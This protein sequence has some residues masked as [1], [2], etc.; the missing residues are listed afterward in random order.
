M[1]RALHFAALACAL[2]FWLAAQMAKKLPLGSGLTSRCRSTARI[3]MAVTLSGQLALLYQHG[4]S[5][6][7]E[8]PSP[9]RWIDAFLAARKTWVGE[10]LYA[11]GAFVLGALI[12]SGW[13][14]AGTVTML[15]AAGLTCTGLGGHAVSSRESWS[16]SGAAL[17]H[18]LLAGL[19]FGGLGPLWLMHRAA[20]MGALPVRWATLLQRFSRMALP[21]MLSVLATGAVV[22]WWSVGGWAALVATPYGLMLCAKIVAVGAV[23]SM[24][25]QLR[26]W[27]ARN[28]EMPATETAGSATPWLAS[29]IVFACCV[30]AAAGTLAALVPAAHDRIDW[31]FGFRLAPQAAWLLRADAIRLPMA[32]A[33]GVLVVGMATA[34]AAWRRSR[35]LAAV[36][37][38]S[39]LVA[40]VAL[41]VPA[42]AVDAYPSTYRAS[43]V[44]Y[45]V[46]SVVTG[47]K[48][49]AKHC[50]SC[51]GING[52]GDGALAANLKPQPANLTEPHLG[53]H[54][55]GDLYWWLTNGFPNSVMPGFSQ[56]TSEV[57]RWD[58]INHLTALS[59]GY[60]ARNLGAKPV[61]RDPWLAAIDFRYQ[62]PDGKFALLSDLRRE[63]AT[64]L[65]LI[66]EAPELQ[67]LRSLEALAPRLAASRVKLI[68]VL[69]PL[70]AAK[71]ERSKSP[72]GLEIVVDDGGEISAAWAYYRRTLSNPDLR[73]EQP[74]VGRVEFLID[75]F[76]FVRARWRADEMPDAPDD[77]PLLASIRQ[78]AAEPELRSPDVHAH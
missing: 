7:A 37:A 2:G 3:A 66:N 31:P 40:S 29:E 10:V 52:R 21:A 63:Q 62:L 18:V 24:A 32:V 45:E 68:V 48:L 70:I 5:L 49:Y 12:S 38:A 51:H 1:I 6:L 78:L 53:W 26:R 59:L 30:V 17:T 61:P 16:V 50:A 19:W 72:F 33:A 9:A 4:L 77:A 58:L 25:A 54:T 22:A 46:S 39:S 41:A 27:L 74:L 56:V 47:S 34:G 14:R 15:L 28:A 69:A 76:G 36:V 8:D 67:R 35:R 20:R 65:V 42:V 55:H 13:L 75:R 43:A 60:Q 11:Q 44:A 57:E 71:V 64:Y 23:L 73:N